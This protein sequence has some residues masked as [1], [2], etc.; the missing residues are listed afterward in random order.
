[1]R[2]GWAMAA[3]IAS[4]VYGL[5]PAKASFAAALLG[6]TEPYCLDT[7]GLQRVISLGLAPDKTLAQVRSQTYRSWVKYRHYGDAAF[8]SRDAQWAFFAERVEAFR[9]GGHEPYFATV[10]A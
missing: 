7:H 3:S 4:H 5:G 9:L 2:D 8:G 6:Y 1:M 10:L